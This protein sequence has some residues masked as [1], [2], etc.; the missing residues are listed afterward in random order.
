MQNARSDI[1]DIAKNYLTY[2]GVYVRWMIKIKKS[3][4]YPGDIAGTLDADGY[5]RITIGGVSLL[6]H[7]FAWEFD[8]GDIPDGM[9]I[10]HKNHIRN[11]NRRENLRVV[12]HKDNGRNTKKSVR[13][14]SGCVGVYWYDSRSKW[15][16]FIGNSGKGERKSLGYYSDWFDAVCARKSAEFALG[17]HENH[18]K[19]EV[20]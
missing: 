1:Y 20:K 16:A 7:R 6:A 19:S 10:D 14:K 17:Y 8:N 4:F 5:V 13:N 9:Q 18:G 15:W 3:K 2:D 11:D 12:T